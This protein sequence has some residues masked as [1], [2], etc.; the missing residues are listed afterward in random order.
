MRK[1]EPP[2]RISPVSRWDKSHC[3]LSTMRQNLPSWY[4]V[5]P[6]VRGDGDLN[7]FEKLKKWHRP[8][9]I[10]PPRKGGIAEIFWSCWS[11]NCVSVQKV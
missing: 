7:A 9:L 3:H 11:K 8:L 10:L 4:P 1:T 5:S 2:S 6:I